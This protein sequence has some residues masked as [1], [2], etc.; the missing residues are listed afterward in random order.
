MDTW[1]ETTIEIDTVNWKGK[2]IH[3]VNV[4]A[5][6]NMKTGQIRVYPSEVAKAEIAMLAEQYDLLPREALILLM[7]YAKPGPFKAGMLHHKYRMNKTLFY[8]WKEMEK[9]GWGDSI[10][11]DQFQPAA[12]GPVPKNLT[13]DLEHLC[14]KKLISLSW[15]TWD[16]KPH[17]K[18]IA[19]EGWKK[20]P[21]DASLITELTREGFQLAEKLWYE[22]PEPLREITLR[23]KERIFPLDPSTIRN[24]VHREYPE[25]KKGY[26]ELDR[27]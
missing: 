23:V 24:R 16:R 26:T 2:P 1:C 7:L 17:E 6:K 9:E 5:L 4:P 3:V 8:Q 18:L 13:C 27:D 15:E 19:W 20:G 12:R 25:Y 21:K 14:E 10:P 11:H 22:V